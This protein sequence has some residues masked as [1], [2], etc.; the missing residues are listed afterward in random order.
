VTPGI[1]VAVVSW[2]TRDLLRRCLEALEPAVSSGLAEVWVVDNGSED[3]SAEMVRSEFEWVSLI[4][5]EENLGFGPAVNEVASRTD[6]EWL[7]PANADIAPAAG[8]LEALLK[9]GRADPSVAI[10]APR[11]VMPDGATQHSVHA[12]PTITLSA[13]FGFGIHRLVP[14][15]GKRLCIEGYWDPSTARE[16]DWAHGAFL[17]VRRT[18]FD[19][20]GGFDPGQWMYAEDLDLAWRSARGGWKVRYEPSAAVAHEVSAAARQ[21]F[22]EARVERYMAATYAWMAERRGIAVTWCFAIV[23]TVAASVRWL[24]FSVMARIGARRFKTARDMARAYTRVHAQGLRTRR[25][26]GTQ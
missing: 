20:V 9:A 23:N 5:S 13:L 2:N 21:A 17:L 12:F 22:G 1:A 19:E 3:G 18:A 7:A 14:G 11:L 10:V 16:V 26:L 6:V 24:A 4:A 25:R 8:A 15:L